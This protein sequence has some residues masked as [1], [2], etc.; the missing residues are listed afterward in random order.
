MV[1]GLALVAGVLLPVQGISGT[2]GED[3]AKAIARLE[4]ELK[5]HERVRQRE[6]LWRRC[7]R[8]RGFKVERNDGRKAVLHA[9]PGHPRLG[10]ASG[11]M[12]TGG[13]TRQ[14]D[15][16]VRRLTTSVPPTSQGREA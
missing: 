3:T 11:R 14:P 1:N 4:D 8:A 5:Q 2:A 15:E 7:G 6:E 16:G 12:E 10:Q 9:F 13:C